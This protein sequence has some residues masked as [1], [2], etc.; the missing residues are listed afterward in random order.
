MNKNDDSG[1]IQHFEEDN[2]AG[3]L[4][5]LSCNFLQVMI[6]SEIGQKILVSTKVLNKC[7]CVKK[8]YMPILPT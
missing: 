2:T 4:P 5:A 7:M 3:K 8:V 6:Y 1:V